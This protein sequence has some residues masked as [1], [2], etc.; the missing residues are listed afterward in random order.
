MN[1]IIKRI[2]NLLDMAE[3]SSSPNEAAI[4]ASR[5]RK[6]MDK[7]QLSDIDVF[8]GSSDFKE[9][10]IAYKYKNMDIAMQSML[11]L[12]GRLNDCILKA[13]IIEEK[14]YVS[15]S[16][17][18]ADSICCKYTAD[19]LVNNCEKE[20]RIRKG[21]TR[22]NSFRRGYCTA[23]KEKILLLLKERKEEI[24]KASSRDLISEKMIN[25]IN[26]YGDPCYIQGCRTR[27]NRNSSYA[28]GYECGR[29]QS[30]NRGVDR[31]S[32]KM[33]GNN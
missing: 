32:T 23:V 16:G 8:L 7:H 27:T 21:P 2:K 20:V 18:T 31:S 33:L 3:D 10:Y 9:D 11:I 28:E 29:K 17:Y 24:K 13:E 22:K 4:A 19:M 1:K 30:L 12:V 14:L 5:A 26:K 25:V 15:F 6:L